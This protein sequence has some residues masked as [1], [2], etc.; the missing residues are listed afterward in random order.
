MS[1]CPKCNREGSFQIKVVKGHSYWYFAHAGNDRPKWHYCGK[2]LPK[3]V[4][5]EKKA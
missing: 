1:L 5:K 4:K 3:G 2:T